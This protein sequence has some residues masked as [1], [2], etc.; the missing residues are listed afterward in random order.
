MFGDVILWILCCFVIG[1]IENCA[2]WSDI[3]KIRLP[4]VLSSFITLLKMVS[5]KVWIQLV[6]LLGEV[7]L[8][9]RLVEYMM[10]RKSENFLF[11]SQ[12]RRLI[13]KS[14]S[15]ITYLFSLINF[16]EI[17]FRYS[18]LKSLCCIHG[19][20]Y[21]HPATKILQSFWITSIKGDSSCL[22]L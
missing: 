3:G 22:F 19:C 6:N 10:S 2:W 16:P 12:F 15:N 20:L 4:A 7:I 21:M 13:M 9:R 8:G 11:E 17:G 1:I 18:S 14:P 5:I